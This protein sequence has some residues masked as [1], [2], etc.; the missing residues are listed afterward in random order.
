MLSDFPCQDD[1]G[2]VQSDVFEFIRRQGKHSNIDQ[3]IRFI[4]KLYNEE[5]HLLAHRNITSVQ[6]L[7]G[8]K[9]NFGVAGS[10]TFMTASLVFDIL[11]VDV[12]PVTFDQG[13]AMEKVKAEEVAAT[14]YV[15]GKPTS[16]FKDLTT[17]DPV[18]FLSVPLTAQILETYLPSRLTS[19][20]YPQVI[21]AGEE[22]KTLAVG[23]VMA[24]YNWRSGHPRRAK[25]G[26][27]IESFFSRFEEFQ[28]APRHPKWKEVS[29][30]AV[31]PGWT[32]FGPAEDWLRKSATTGTGSLRVAF[33]EFLQSQAPNLAS[34][35]S[36]EQRRELFDLF[37]RW[38]N[39]TA[40]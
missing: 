28:E 35:M 23:A 14:V 26:R 16:A 38:Q 13:L 22:V 19:E 7:A 6:D 25:V 10:G 8:K 36:D 4:T 2:I 12:E 15:A 17:G 29:L 5:F 1:I 9:V 31:V 32:R 21:P 24:V 33:D 27:F 40:Q 11:G 20:D 30:T 3:R 39:E 37:L 18:H 34:G